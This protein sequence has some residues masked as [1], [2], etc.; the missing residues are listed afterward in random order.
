MRGK[1]G[2][3]LSPFELALFVFWELKEAGVLC[4]KP[5]ARRTGTA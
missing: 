2:P 3:S 4:G 5:L 1:G